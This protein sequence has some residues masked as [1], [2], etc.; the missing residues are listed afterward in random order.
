MF[1]IVIAG[2]PIISEFLQQ[3]ETRCISPIAENMAAVAEVSFFL[4]PGAALPPGFGAL[5]HYAAAPFTEWEVIGGIGPDRPSGIFRTGWNTRVTEGSSVQFDVQFGV[6][7]E[8]LDTMSNLEI[9]S[10]GVEDRLGF[11]RKLAENLYNF[12]TSFSSG[13]PGILQVPSDVFDRWLAVFESKFKRDPN[14]FIK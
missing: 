1:G 12:M 13:T 8:P 5:L 3:S 4:L 9:A 10:K 14:F 6:S 7:L 11:A 2:R